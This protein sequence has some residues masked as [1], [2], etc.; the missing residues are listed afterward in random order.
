MSDLVIPQSFN[1]ASGGYDI[2]NIKLPL[3]VKDVTLMSE[4]IWNNYFYELSEIKKSFKNT[5]WGFARN[6][7]LFYDH[8]DR[9]AN[10]FIGSIE[11]VRLKEDKLVGDL[12][13]IDENAA[14][15]VL[16]S[17]SNG[18]L[19]GVSA[20]VRGDDVSGK[21]K[22]FIFEN[23]SVVA[24]P[25][26]KTAYINSQQKG[27]EMSDVNKEELKKTIEEIM[28]SKKKEEQEKE[29]NK[30]QDK[31]DIDSLTKNI[32]ERVNEN[33]K[34]ELERMEK[35]R[36]EK[37][38]QAKKEAEAQ[39]QEQEKQEQ[40]KQE[41]EKQEQEK[42]ETETKEED[43]DENKI[44]DMKKQAA[45][46]TV[47]QDDETPEYDDVDAGMLKHIKEKI[48]QEQIE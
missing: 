6:R 39:K 9:D 44:S 4:G 32:I 34:T 24:D 31:L 45:R 47:R 23:F 26:V 20:K 18:G 19:I 15:K 14:R 16:W 28:E 2:N 5:D 40:E 30:E 43:K 10:D 46:N 36:Q 13:I 42:Q 21:V 38:E 41:Q 29:Q 48:K 3:V 35:E 1:L 11:N 33:M 27:D 7:R 8:N 25:A 17:K 22:N 37:E 12:Y